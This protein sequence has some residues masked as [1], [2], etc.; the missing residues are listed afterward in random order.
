MISDVF[1]MLTSVYGDWSHILANPRYTR[2]GD[3][4]TWARYKPFFMSEPARYAEI[5]KV[6]SEGQYSFQMID[7]S[8]IQIYYEF[9]AGGKILKTAK[10]AYYGL[11]NGREEEDCRGADIGAEVK[12]TDSVSWLR[13]DYEL[14]MTQGVLHSDCHL[15]TCGFPNSRFVVRGV[16]TP[17]QFI[18]FLIA[19]RYSEEYKK[20]RLDSNGRY[21]DLDLIR[22]INVPTLPLKDN[23]IFNVVFHFRVPSA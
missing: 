13:F 1:S 19:L 22:K 16:P 5:I 6:V 4:I 20:H 8:V 23:D 17:K 10:L 2:N 7:G 18:E 12:K 21:R 14:T 9:Q 15:H 11:N 3:V